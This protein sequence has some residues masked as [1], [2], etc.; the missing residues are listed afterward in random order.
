[1]IPDCTLTTACFNLNDFHN[2]SRSLDDC[3]NSMKSLLEVPCYIVIY[4]DNYCYD[5][6]YQKKIKT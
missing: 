1:M 3:I 4:T 2:K 6:I 5:K